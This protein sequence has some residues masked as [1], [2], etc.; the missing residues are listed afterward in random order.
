MTRNGHRRQK[1]SHERPGNQGVRQRR[2]P[3][4]RDERSGADRPFGWTER[5]T[6]CNTCTAPAGSCS[7]AGCHDGSRKMA[8][9]LEPCR[10]VRECLLLHLARRRGVEGCHTDV[11]QCRGRNGRGQLP[12]PPYERS[13]LRPPAMHHPP[14]TTLSPSATRTDCRG[15]HDEVSHLNGAYHVNKPRTWSSKTAALTTYPARSAKHRMPQRPDPVWGE[16]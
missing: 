11:S 2:L 12:Q 5:K 9:A 16:S 15:K 13:S 10:A 8:A 14:S 3:P 4:R 7:S 6:N 1:P